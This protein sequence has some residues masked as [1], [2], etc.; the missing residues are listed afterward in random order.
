MLSS[1]ISYNKKV[2]ISILILLLILGAYTIYNVSGLRDRHSKVEDIYA[3][4][5][6]KL[7]ASGSYDDID[8]SLIKKDFDDIGNIIKEQITI[9]LENNVDDES[10]IVANNI[11]TEKMSEFTKIMNHK[12]D[13]ETYKI[14]LD[15]IDNFEK[16][17]KFNLDAKKNELLSESEFARYKNQ[18]SYYEKQRFLYEMLEKYKSFIE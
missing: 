17:I 10:F 7:V 2:V 3:N 15:D 13:E 6:S 1:L 16:D 4:Q 18:Y 8:Y 11:Y 14:Y 5:L 12:L 9:N